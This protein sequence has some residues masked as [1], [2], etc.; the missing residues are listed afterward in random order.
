MLMADG[1]RLDESPGY[2]VPGWGLN[3]PSQDSSLTGI[4]FIEDGGAHEAMVRWQMM[5]GVVVGNI[6]TAWGPKNK[7]LASLGSI[8]DPVKPLSIRQ[9]CH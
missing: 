5:L 2:F 8:P 6:V 3:T 9:Q 4:R 1:W 7:E